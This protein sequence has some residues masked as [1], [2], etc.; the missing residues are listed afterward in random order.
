MLRVHHLNCGTMCPL[1][2]R[3]IDG[4]SK[5]VSSNL[6]CHCLL[7][8]SD[9][10]LIL[11]DTG[12]GLEDIRHPKKRLSL[13]FRG[14]DRVKLEEEK[15]A[16][17]QIEKL[18]FKSSDVRHIVLTHLDSDHAGGLTDFPH[19]H[20]H[21]MRDELIEARRPRSLTDRMRYSPEQWSHIQ[22]WNIY[23]PKGEAW[24]GFESVR[25]LKGLPPEILLVPLVGHTWGHTGVAIQTQNEWLFHA[26]DA[27]FYRGEMNPR[28]YHCTPGLRF[29][30]AMLEVNR[31]LRLWNQ[32]RLRTLVQQHR[33]EVKVFSAHDAV[34]LDFFQ[35]NE[36]KA[37]IYQHRLQPTRESPRPPAPAPEGFI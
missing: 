29:Y 18:G 8:E 33:R 11:V 16:L 24:F 14:L 7:I 31:P 20:I 30:Q 3:Y 25:S 37:L 27:Y 34:E 36:Q 4:F 13:F 5:G 23:Q 19:A 26:G 35:K 21:L 32:K 9:Q 10:G 15:T 28:Q 1:G 12:F 17:R 22:N 6:V 2:G